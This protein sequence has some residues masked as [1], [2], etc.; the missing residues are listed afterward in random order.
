LPEI[1]KQKGKWKRK[2]E[3]ERERI[4]NIKEIVDK[5]TEKC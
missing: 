1:E 4:Q 5:A 3:R 2:R